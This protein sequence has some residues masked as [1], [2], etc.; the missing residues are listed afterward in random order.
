MCINLLF[1]KYTSK[2]NAAKLQ[3]NTILQHAII[4]L[5]KQ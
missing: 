1:S 2:Q 5:I 3:G 4:L